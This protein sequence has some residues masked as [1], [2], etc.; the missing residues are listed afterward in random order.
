MNYVLDSVG[1][2]QELTTIMELSNGSIDYYDNNNINI[3]IEGKIYS[4]NKDTEKITR[5]LDLSVSYLYEIYGANSKDITNKE[6]QQFIKDYG[7]NNS[8]LMYQ[9]LAHN[10]TSFDQMQSF[11]LSNYKFPG[12]SFDLTEANN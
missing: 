12:D 8:V 1:N 9:T 7:V 3:N 10:L 2:P 4:K 5:E 11:N 6:I